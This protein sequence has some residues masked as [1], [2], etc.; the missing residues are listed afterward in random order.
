MT[1]IHTCNAKEASVPTRALSVVAGLLSRAT[2]QKTLWLAVLPLLLAVTVV[3][4]EPALVNVVSIPG[5]NIDARK[6]KPGETAGANVNRLG[7]FSDLFYDRKT[8]YWYALS[9]RGPGGGLVEY[10]T[11]VQ[12]MRIP[13]NRHTGVVGTPVIDRTILFKDADGQPFNGLNPGL[14]N[15]DKS[16]LGLSFDPE[17]IVVGRGGHLFVADEYGPSLYEF[18]PRGRFLRA[19]EIPDD[20]QPT[21]SD[22]TRNYVDGRDGLTPITS[23]RQDNRGF[24]GLAINPAGTKLYGVLQDPL[25]NEGSNND[26]RRSRNTRLVEFDIASGQSTAQYI[27]QLESRTTLNNL[28]PDTAD[29][30]SATSQGRNIGLSAIVAIND[31]DFLVLERDNRGLGIELTPTPLH[32]RIYR[33][34]LHGATD[35]QHL[36]LAN[37]DDL[38]SGVIPVSK[39]PFIDVLAQLTGQS[40]PEKLEGLAIGPRLADGSY[41]ILLGTDNDYSVTQTGEGEQFDICVDTTGTLREQVPIDQGCPSD[42]ALIPGFLMSFKGT[43]EAYQPARHVHEKDDDVDD[44]DAKD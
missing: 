7:F 30:F 44:D 19:F 25:V 2:V 6:L 33:I 34:S 4:S 15:D 26:G 42:L 43:I 39:E 29:D 21:Q 17:G 9:D 16:I 14:L 41:A 10:A 20:L 36:S 40:V 38:P 8:G 1:L 35:V 5:D 32:K 27:Y 22:G 24:E 18:S 37:S 12:R 31:I 3:A 23:G 11:R 13:V 28:T